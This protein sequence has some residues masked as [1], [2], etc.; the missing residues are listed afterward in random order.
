MFHA[1][2]DVVA[3]NDDLQGRSDF[4]REHH[5]STQL[6]KP[7]LKIQKMHPVGV[8]RVSRVSRCSRHK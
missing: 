3:M 5:A 8:K 2:Q 6:I 7:Q 1:Y 4:S